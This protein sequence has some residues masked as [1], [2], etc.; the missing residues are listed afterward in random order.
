M[1]EDLLDSVVFSLV[2]FV[3]FV[4][5]VYSFFIDDSE[6]QR[7]RVFMERRHGITVQDQ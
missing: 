2:L 4:V 6:Q 7:Y 5:L 3:S 1:A